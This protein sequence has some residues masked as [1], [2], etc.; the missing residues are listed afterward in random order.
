M[1]NQPGF[2][3]LIPGQAGSVEGLPKKTM[4]IAGAKF[5]NNTF[6][7]ILKLK[8]LKINI[9]I[10]IYI[11]IYNG[12]ARP[13]FQKKITKRHNF[14]LTIVQV[15]KL[16]KIIYFW[17]VKIQRFAENRKVAESQTNCMQEF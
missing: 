8:L 13:L 2:P 16:C 11:Y 1:F 3:Q 4:G 9:Y 10:Y 17:S 15:C 7:I 6:K 5:P 14:K 12:T